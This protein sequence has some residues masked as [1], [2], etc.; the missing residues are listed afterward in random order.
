[1]DADAVTPRDDVLAPLHAT[2]R[3]I[4]DEL[5]PF[6]PDLA[7]AATGSKATE[8]PVDRWTATVR[9]RASTLFACGSA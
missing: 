9:A 3:A 6:V 1:M 2:T 8:A 4:V 5:A 7:A